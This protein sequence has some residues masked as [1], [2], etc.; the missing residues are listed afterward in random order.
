[1]TSSDYSTVYAVLRA[2]HVVDRESFTMATFD[3]RNGRPTGGVSAHD[4]AHDL[5]RALGRCRDADGLCDSCSGETEQA[6]EERPS[7]M[8]ED[9]PAAPTG[10]CNGCTPHDRSG[11][12]TVCGA[13][14]CV[15]CRRVPVIG[16]FAVCG[17]CGQVPAAELGHFE[18]ACR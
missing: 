3:P 18:L 7:L 17:D 14:L 8:E 6:D 10:C 2:T 11:T 12:C 13:A 1:M 5:L 9:E 15:D 4:F 16:S